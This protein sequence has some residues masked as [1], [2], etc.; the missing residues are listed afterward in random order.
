M[1]VFARSNGVGVSHVDVV[2]LKNMTA[3]DRLSQNPTVS[4]ALRT[5]HIISIP[6]WV[7]GLGNLNWAI[8]SKLRN[9]PQFVV[10]I[11]LDPVLIAPDGATLVGIER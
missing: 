7:G 3:F 11:N 6:I 5:H 10:S 4:L 1:E 2:T 9:S 8:V